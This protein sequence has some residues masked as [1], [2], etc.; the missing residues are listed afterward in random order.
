MA[1][2]TRWRALAACA[3][4]R[5]YL[6][7]Q[8]LFAFRLRR[9]AN[10]QAAQD[11]LEGLSWRYTAIVLI[12]LADEPAELAREILHGQPREAVC[13]RLIEHASQTMDLGEVAL[14]LWA[15]RRLEQRAG[16]RTLDR[17]RA[18]QPNRGRCATVELAWSLSAL[19]ARSE[20]ETDFALAEALADR[21]RTSQATYSGLF[22][23]CVPADQ[24]GSWLRGHVCCFADLV[25]PIQALSL[26]HHLTGD[27]RAKEAV[28]RCVERMCQLQGPAG[29][30]W[31]HYDVRT[32]RVIEPYPVYAVHQDAMGPMALFAARNFCGAHA[33]EALARSVAWLERAPEIEGSLVDRTAGVIWRK[34]CR[35]EP[36]KLSRGVQALAS[37]VHAGLRVPGLDALFPP[38]GIDHES[39][40]YHMGWILFAWGASGALG[41]GE[42]LN[43]LHASGRDD[44]GTTQR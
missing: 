37:R 33:D 13:E 6:S 24:A 15:A 3:L 39:R 43:V 14:T 9:G 30:W 32:G 1:V 10:G 34:V 41:G 5:M 21:L 8:G 11:Q 26:Y 2:A 18:W 38:R 4:P 40:P 27:Q 29:Q 42:S 22:P 28:V 12:A 7:D 36:A 25:Y 44:T 20:Q 35:R 23:H 16:V 19:V 17:L 31:W